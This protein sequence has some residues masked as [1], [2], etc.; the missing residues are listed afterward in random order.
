MAVQRMLLAGSERAPQ[1][2]ARLAGTPS[3]T[4]IIEVT[5]V[6][7]R[8]APL[9]LGEHEA[10]ISREAFTAQYG[11]SPADIQSIED[12]AQQFDLT[13][14]SVTRAAARSCCRARSPR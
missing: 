11:A 14:V 2:D 1:A 9:N 12:F 13:V 7:R 10:P 5:V 8:R 4:D 3:L 6:L